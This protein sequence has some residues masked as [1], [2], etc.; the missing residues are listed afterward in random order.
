MAST[1]E[2]ISNILLGGLDNAAN[3]LRS[4]ITQ[5]KAELG[6]LTERAIELLNNSLVDAERRNVP[7]TDASLSAL[8]EQLDLLG[9]PRP[10]AGSKALAGQQ[11]AIQKHQEAL[12]AFKDPNETLREAFTDPRKQGLLV[13]IKDALF[14][15]VDDP[16]LQQQ[17]GRGEAGLNLLRNAAQS[18]PE[19]PL[20]GIRG[21]F[22]DQAVD[23]AI[24]R[25]GQEG[26][27]SQEV[28]PA[29]TALEQT[30]PGVTREASLERLRNDPG[31]QFQVEEANRGLLRQKAATG[32]LLSGGTLDAITRLNQDLASTRFQDRLNQLQNVVN[33]GFQLTSQQNQLGSTAAQAQGGLLSN[34][35]QANLQ[36]QTQLGK[37]LGQ[38][39]ISKA[40]TK[41]NR[42]LGDVDFFGP[43]QTA[44]LLGSIRI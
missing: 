30:D 25:L 31:F 41:G 27:V 14:S 4:S 18:N 15:N 20:A 10:V 9:L 44:G 26:L 7:F 37:G 29:P 35:G 23:S 11:E 36:A 2:K 8:D 3:V 5:G 32:S 43:Q 22:G 38:L 40:I 16:F 1:A 17:V 12:A 6:S 21:T 33:P 39:E 24:T 28:G 42:L 34:Q 13:P 19:N